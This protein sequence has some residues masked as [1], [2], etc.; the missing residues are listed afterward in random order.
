MSISAFGWL[1]WVGPFVARHRSSSS[2]VAEGQP[3]RWWLAR[4]RSARDSH[5]GG[6]S[7]GVVALVLLAPTF[8]LGFI[9][10]APF[11]LLFTLALL[12]CCRCACAVG[13]IEGILVQESL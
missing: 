3:R 13:T 5:W 9:K 8:D 11:V 12:E 4:V 6:A 1:F 10:G 2:R 7:L